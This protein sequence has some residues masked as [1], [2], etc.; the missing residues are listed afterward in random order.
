MCI[1]VRPLPRVIRMS[2]RRTVRTSHR[3]SVQTR[4]CVRRS[5]MHG[6]QCLDYIMS[7]HTLEW[8][9]RCWEQTSVF[10]ATTVIYDALY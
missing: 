3:R 2:V 7:S 9:H 1:Y 4:F 10:Y 8:D 6:S 5:A